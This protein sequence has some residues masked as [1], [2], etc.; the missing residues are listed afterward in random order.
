MNW[1]ISVVMNS[2]NFNG[3][4][5]RKEYWMFTGFNILIFFGI[6]IIGDM[7]QTYFVGSGS[8]SE[9]IA[10]FAG[11]YFVASFIPQL[12]LSIRRL[13]DT[14]RSGWNLLWGLMPAI[15]GIIMFVFTVEK[16]VTGD[17]R[18]GPDPKEEQEDYKL[19]E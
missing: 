7:L 14:N 17:N 19:Y 15:G 6:F 2:F 4:A 9:V 11:L 13:H 1:Y 18:F 10:N 8:A 5:R 16:G 3:R 12:A